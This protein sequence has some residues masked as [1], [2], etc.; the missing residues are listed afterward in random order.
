M[1]FGGLAVV[2]GFGLKHR[3]SVQE[4]CTYSETFESAKCLEN[5][6]VLLVCYLGN[7]VLPMR[8]LTPRNFRVHRKYFAKTNQ[9]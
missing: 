7:W 4:K 2:R 8:G 5:L 1:L 9:V 3:T 6:G